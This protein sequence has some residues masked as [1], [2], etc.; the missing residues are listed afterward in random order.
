[1]CCH[2]VPLYVITHGQVA[3]DNGQ[4]FNYIYKHCCHDNIVQVHVVK[5]SGRFIPR[6]CFS[7]IVYT[8]IT[9]KDMVTVL[10]YVT[11]N[12]MYYYQANK[13]QPVPREPYDGPVIQ[14]DK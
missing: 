6:P 14:L 7:D 9:Q 10:N 5:G 12:R 2:G 13:P 4:V 1:M 3:V 8:A 11:N